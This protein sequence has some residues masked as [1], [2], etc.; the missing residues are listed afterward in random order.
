M[1]SLPVLKRGLRLAA[2][3]LLVRVTASIVSNYGGYAPP[4]FRVGF[5]QGR[6][7]SFFG[8]YAWAFYA[9]I[10]SGPVAMLLGLFLVSDLARS[11]WPRWHRWLGRIQ[12]F[13]VVCVVAPSGLAMAF[14]PAAGLAAGLSLATLAILTAT[15]ALIGA[16]RARCRRFVLH[17]IWMWRCLLLLCSAIVLRV[18]VGLGIVLGLEGRMLD[19]SA[20]WGSWVVPLL[21]NEAYRSVRARRGARAC[22][23]WISSHVGIVDANPASQNLS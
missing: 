19:V 11:R 14:R 4:D 13:L 17:R 16:W 9:H 10:A 23:L 18:T 3:I 21:C 8:W 12:V 22:R 20:T 1:V 15:T 6:E 5:L 7:G 2:A